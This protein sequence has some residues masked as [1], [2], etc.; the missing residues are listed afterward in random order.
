MGGMRGAKCFGR[1]GRFFTTRWDEEQSSFL[2]I[3]TFLTGG[4]NLEPSGCTR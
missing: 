2:P 1:V 3:I 4:S